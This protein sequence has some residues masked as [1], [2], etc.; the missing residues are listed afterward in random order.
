MVDKLKQVLVA[1]F[2]EEIEE[3]QFV[4][5]NEVIGKVFEADNETG[6]ALVWFKSS[7]I[8]RMQ[9]TFWSMEEHEKFLQ[10]LILYGTDWPKVAGRVKSKSVLES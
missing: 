3:G 9:E 1:E 10:A 4:L 5:R 2:C 8:S 7:D 6:G